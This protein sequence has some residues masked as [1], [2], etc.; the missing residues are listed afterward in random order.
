MPPG[1]QEFNLIARSSRSRFQSLLGSSST[2][3][4]VAL[5]AASALIAGCGGSDNNDD[6]ATPPPPGVPNPPPAG[7]VTASNFCKADPN[8]A[9]RASVTGSLASSAT[10]A[11]GRT[12]TFAV[13]TQPTRGELTLG[14][15]GDFTYT[16]KV[17][18]AGQG[19]G[20]SFTYTVSDGTGGR[21][22]ATAKIVYGKSRIMPLGDSI[23]EG[24][25]TY[26]GDNDVGPPTEQRVAYRYKLHQL[27]T[28]AGYAF[29]FV[30]S[31]TNGQAATPPLI[32]AQNE[33]HG[34]IQI[35]QLAA[36][37]QYGASYAGLTPALT[38]GKPDIVLLH[39]G[40]NDA[41]KLPVMEAAPMKSLLTSAGAW[42]SANQPVQMVVARIIKFRTGT[43]NAGNVAT[44]NNLVTAMI[45]Q[46]FA[47][48]TGPLKVSQADFESATI[49]MTDAANDA[50]GLHP[51]RAGYD[52]MAQVWFDA[53]VAQKIIDRC[54]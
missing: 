21:A 39:A 12:L 44:L 17:G 20:D 48:T 34:G 19:F 13:A 3:A 52:Q 38:A 8:A 7:N 49:A 37:A 1:P 23:T 31:K 30:G 41:D 4:A 24:V 45:K 36:D 33:G 47:S 43:P 42:A 15:G 46:D 35:G 26:R 6:G 54:E 29:D 11:A 25:E 22:T 40:T 10:G 16:P 27:L 51:S 9:N 28:Q 18:D 2:R 14:A 53:L 50:T 32:D 5:I